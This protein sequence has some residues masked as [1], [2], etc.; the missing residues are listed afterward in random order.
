LFPPQHSPFPLSFLL[1][2]FS[3]LLS[4]PI[5]V[6]NLSPTPFPPCSQQVTHFLKAPAHSPLLNPHSA[7]RTPQS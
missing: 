5:G 2:G 7:L 4:P 3:F 6:Q 1:H